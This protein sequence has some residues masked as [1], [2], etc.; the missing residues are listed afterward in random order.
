MAVVERGSLADAR[1]AG[2]A[3]PAKCTVFRETGEVS[4]VCKRG[5]AQTIEETLCAILFIVGAIA[6]SGRTLCTMNESGKDFIAGWECEKYRK[7]VA[8]RG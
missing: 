8:G 2:A 5:E 7:S 3:A 4:Y 1:A 6:R